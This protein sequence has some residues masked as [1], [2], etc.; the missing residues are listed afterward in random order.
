MKILLIDPPGWQKGVLNVGLAYLAS[1]LETKGF[2]VQVADA[3]N[4]FLSGEELLNI[5]TDYDPTVIGY[6]INTGTVSSTIKMAKETKELFPHSIHVA[7]GPHISL[8]YQEFLTQNREFDYAFLQE[9]EETFPLFCEKLSSRDSISDV[10]GIAFINENDELVVNQLEKFPDPNSLSFPD[11]G[12]FY[13]Y[14]RE[15]LQKRYPLVTSRG[16]PY[17]CIFCTASKICGKKWR[18]RFAQD[19]IEELKLAR[20]KYGIQRF[21]I[22]DDNFTFNLRRAKRLCK[23]F[24]DEKVKLE[25]G[26]PNGI[27]A[28]KID[29]ELAELMRESGCDMVCIGVESGDKE[30]FDAIKKGETLQEIEK[31]IHLLKSV[32]IK[33]TG[34]FIIGLPG[35]NPKKF[36]KSLEFVKKTEL[37]DA[38]FGLLIPFQGTEVYEWVDKN[39]RFLRD[40][41]EAKFFGPD[42]RPIFET[43]Q[44]TEKE[45]IGCYQKACT[46]TGNFGRMIPAD[47]S[48]FEKK[49][50]KQKLLW[51]YDQKRIKRHLFLFLITQV[52]NEKIWVFLRKIYNLNRRISVKIKNLFKKHDLPY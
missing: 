47:L 17:N 10:P 30:V 41:D 26:C 35:D 1:S 12:K 31:S 8:F 40:F 2:D 13:P 27:R 7:G 20:S 5:L 33:V 50:L 42:A 49:K 19:V 6:S 38:W 4:N 14:Q 21:D 23:V 45:M 32:G 51:K 52:I 37:D 9:A 39:G 16:C 11:Y 43:D 29:Q 48:G 24:I 25:W 15:L 22:V 3:N 34:L 28:D 44:F 18:G 36:N 46:A